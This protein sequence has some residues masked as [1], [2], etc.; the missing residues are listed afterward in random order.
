MNNKTL[1]QHIRSVADQMLT[2]DTVVL[3][4]GWRESR[5]AKLEEYLARQLGMKVIWMWAIEMVVL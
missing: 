1:P 4:D 2:C 3:L 5:G